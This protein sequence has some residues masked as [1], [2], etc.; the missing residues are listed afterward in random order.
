ML[1]IETSTLV[2][3]WSEEEGGIPQRIAPVGPKRRLSFETAVLS[4]EG[5]KRG[6]SFFSARFE[7]RQT[8]LPLSHPKIPQPTPFSSFSSVSPWHS[9]LVCWC[10]FRSYVRDVLWG[11]ER[12]KMFPTFSG[13]AS[14][15]PQRE[16]E[17][18]GKR[19]G[20]EAPKDQIL[21]NQTNKLMTKKLVFI[22]TESFLIVFCGKKRYLSNPA[23]LGAG[24]ICPPV[25]G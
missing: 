11:A 2:L 24:P 18:R 21:C 1:Q 12:K 7:P 10:H 3:C 9:L 22:Q 20:F 4:C 6:N 16:R 17:E 23:P 8:S 15:W 14:I 19:F 13:A 25:K 5:G